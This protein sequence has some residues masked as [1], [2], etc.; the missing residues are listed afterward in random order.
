[1]GFEKPTD[2]LLQALSSILVAN[3]EDTFVDS[4]GR[5]VNACDLPPD[6]QR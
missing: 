6:P 1:M 5:L 4:A 2:Y 3:E